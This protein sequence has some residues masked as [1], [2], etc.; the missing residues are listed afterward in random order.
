MAGHFEFEVTLGGSKNL[1]SADAV[2]RC[3]GLTPSCGIIGTGGG[4]VH[5]VFLKYARDLFNST[6]ELA[7]AKR[8]WRN[9][10]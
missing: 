3:H 4:K 1:L 6:F 10:R 9:S 5:I 8:E 7:E 2:E